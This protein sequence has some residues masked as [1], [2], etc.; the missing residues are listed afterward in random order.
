VF[1]DAN[2]VPAKPL[3]GQYVGQYNYI[4]NYGEQTQVAWVYPVWWRFSGKNY[5]M[6]SEDP[7]SSLCEPR[8]QYVLGDGIEFLQQDEGG[9]CSDPDRNPTGLFSLRQP[10]DSVVMM[11]IDGD[12]CRQI[13]LVPAEDD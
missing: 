10:M 11:Q 9:P 12:I 5:W 4:V 6:T 13:L 2:A 8:G 7:Y 3:V 1:Y